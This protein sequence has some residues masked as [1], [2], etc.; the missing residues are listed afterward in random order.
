MNI[1]LIITIAMCII[2]FMLQKHY[3]IGPSILLGGLFMWAVKAPDPMHFIT[4][5]Y[6][7]LTMQR[8]YDLL[9]ALYFV[10]CLEI[11]LRTSGSLDGMVR[12]LQRLFPSEK[13]TLAIMHGSLLISLL[14]NISQMRIKN[15]FNLLLP[16]FVN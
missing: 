4:A 15:I 7:T 3:P 1:F 12:A 10:M 6:Q 2:L 11:E 13:F 8:T 5:G 16:G 9:F 14:D